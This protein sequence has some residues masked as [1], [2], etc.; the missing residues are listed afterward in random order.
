MVT[1]H[2]RGLGF[3]R[4]VL[5]RSWNGL[6]RGKRYFTLWYQAPVGTEDVQYKGH[7]MWYVTALPNN[8]KIADNG[9]TA[10]TQRA[11]ITHLNLSNDRSKNASGRN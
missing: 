4:E 10:A 8:R 11:M 9:E 6:L 3:M 2:L 1:N 7:W 5:A